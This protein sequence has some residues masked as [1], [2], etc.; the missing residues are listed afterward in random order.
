MWPANM[1]PKSRRA[2][3]SGRMMKYVA[4]SRTKITGAIQPG[5]PGGT[6]C[7]K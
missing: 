7:L 2:S 6:M 5:T 4:S 3:V 1:L